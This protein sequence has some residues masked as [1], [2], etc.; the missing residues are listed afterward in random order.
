MYSERNW[1]VLQMSECTFGKCNEWH[2]KGGHLGTK[3][4]LGTPSG[5]PHFDSIKLQ[6]SSSILKT[7]DKEKPPAEV[8]S[9]RWGFLGTAYGDVSGKGC[10]RG[11]CCPKDGSNRGNGLRNRGDCWWRTNPSVFTKLICRR[12]PSM[13]PKWDS[14]EH[15]TT[16]QSPSKNSPQREIW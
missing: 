1:E 6:L 13:W 9:D 5:S 10:V 3:V 16:P 11:L 15:E 2:S 7:V 14:F 12:M 4:E 8:A